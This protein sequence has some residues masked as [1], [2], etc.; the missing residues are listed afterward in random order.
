MSE[1]AK[2][3]EVRFIANPTQMA[4]IRS[5]AEADLFACRMGEGKSA[6]LVWSIYYH[7]RANPGATWA[8]IRDT[9]EN[10]RKTTQKEFFKWFPDG[11]FGTYKA[12]EKTFTWKAEGMSGE[13]LF[14]GMDTEEDASKLQSLELAGFGMDEPAPAA[15]SGGIDEMIFN[16]AVTRLRQPGMKWYPVKLAENN[17]DE[18]HWTYK[19]FADPDTKEDGYE[20]FQ[21]VEPENLQNLPR[22]Y[23]ERT[24]KALRGRPDLQRRF[25]EGH[26]GFQK[27]GEAV[28]PQ[29]SDRLHLTEGLDR[30]PRV[31]LICL[32]D[33]GLNPTCILTQ[34]S[35]LGHWL[36][37][38]SFVGEGIG[39]YQLIEQFIKP[40]IQTD[41]KGLELRHIGDP[42]GKTR[43]QSNAEQS[44][45]K[46]IRHQLGGRWTPG[47]VE[48]DERRDP[49]CWVLSQ[50]LNGVGLIQVDKYKAQEVYHALRGGWH[51][52]K[53]RGGVVGNRPV[54]D[55]NSHPGD[56][57]G[58]GAAVLFPQARLHGKKGSRPR[59]RQFN[60]WGASRG[61]GSPGVRMPPEGQ[62]IRTG[63]DRR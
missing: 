38:K 59:P 52:P 54:K 16:V 46:V 15:S 29:W 12:S 53:S 9:W 4:F 26:F 55:G 21:T 11:V 7:T 60:Q 3:H 41:F 43:E 37:L 33:F 1:S 57:M 51:F 42:A 8:L 2:T 6:A 27:V 5:R 50:A 30:I 13:V 48:F 62:V 47:P 34:V 20:C 22:G 40:V 32:W 44:A 17:P 24:R 49:L 19:R 39:A 28:T 25:V 36:I 18:G 61:P 56:A 31:P 23:Y 10:L 63:R 45:V 14:L 35:P 58:Y